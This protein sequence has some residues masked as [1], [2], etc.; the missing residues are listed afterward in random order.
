MICI[1]LNHITRIQFDIKEV[2]SGLHAN[3]Q[4]CVI[5][6][7][8]QINGSSKF[9]NKLSIGQFIS[10][11]IIEKELDRTDIEQKVLIT[12]INDRFN[13]DGRTSRYRQLSGRSNISR[14]PSVKR[15][16]N[17]GGNS[18]FGESPTQS[19]TSKKKKGLVND[20]RSLLKY[21][22]TKPNEELTR[23]EIN[24]RFKIKSPLKL[25]LD[26]I[27]HLLLF[28]FISRF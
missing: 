15:K 19:S 10:E 18:C 3:L 7:K 5:T 17:S 11:E 24:G 21:I 20:N 27:S 23:D 13:M 16:E 12:L 1:Q 25:E 14:S 6:L 4:V 26:K 28:F 9:R 2:F 8:I 22:T